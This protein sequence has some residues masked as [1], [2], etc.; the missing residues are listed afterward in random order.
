MLL[1]PEYCPDVRAPFHTGQLTAM[2]LLANA[3]TYGTCVL[4]HFF[5]RSFYSLSALQFLRTLH[6]PGDPGEDI[7]EHENVAFQL[8]QSFYLWPKL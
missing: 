8:L 7:L 4:I 6:D 5:L 3:M 1:K 2:R